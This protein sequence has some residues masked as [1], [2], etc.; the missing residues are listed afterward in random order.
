VEFRR[1]LPLAYCA[2][3]FVAWLNFMLLPPD[4]LANLGL[5]LVV[6]PVTLID[7]ALRPSS[8]PAEAVLVPDGLGY[9]VGHT[10]Y[11]AVA[12]VVIAAALWW[13][14]RFLDRVLGR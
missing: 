14:G 10:V 8:A 12:V 1:I 11:F 13:F 9:Y 4:G 7:L 2:V 3:A 6:F 5:M